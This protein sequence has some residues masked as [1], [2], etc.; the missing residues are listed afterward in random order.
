MFRGQAREPEPA[1]QTVGNNSNIDAPK[2]GAI[3][4][5]QRPC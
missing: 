5:S 2:L 4:N 3:L 1:Q